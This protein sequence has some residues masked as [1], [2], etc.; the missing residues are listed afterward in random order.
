MREVAFFSVVI[1]RAMAA[2]PLSTYAKSLNN[3]ANPNASLLLGYWAGPQT[4]ASKQFYQEN[5]DD[6]ISFILIAWI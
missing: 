1:P 4:S 6:F 5:F 2:V 3:G